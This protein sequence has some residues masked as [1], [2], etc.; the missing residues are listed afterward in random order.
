VPGPAKGRPPR[1]KDIRQL[2]YKSSLLAK[3]QK[4]PPTCASLKSKFPEK[5]FAGNRTLKEISANQSSDRSGDSGERRK[6]LKT[7][8]CG[9]LPKA[10][11]PV[12]NSG[13]LRFISP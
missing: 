3:N 7:E 1:P 4:N 6:R 8:E 2:V 10:A 11:T 12:L 9:F 5:K 13:E